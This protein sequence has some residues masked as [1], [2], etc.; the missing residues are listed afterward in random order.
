MLPG[1]VFTFRALG[2]RAAKPVLPGPGV[3]RG[4]PAPDPLGHP[5]GLDVR[6][7]GRAAV[8]Q[9]GLVRVLDLLRDHRRP[10]GSCAGLDAGPGG[11]GD[12][13]REAAQDLAL[14]DGQPVDRLGDRAGQAPGA[15]A[16]RGSPS[17]RQRAGVEPAGAAGGNR[18]A[19]GP[20]GLRGDVQ[21]GMVPGCAVDL[22]LDD[23]AARP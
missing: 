20:A 5:L 9:G 18:P 16:L 6:D 14:P 13:R 15:D 12:R 17:G 2:H 8:S 4:D 3:L 1:P 19:V 11:C 22:G 21:H 10:G 23:R 7:R